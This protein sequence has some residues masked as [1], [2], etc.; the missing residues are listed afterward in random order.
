MKIVE[1][2]IHKARSLFEAI[3]IDKIGRPLKK[4]CEEVKQ[5]IENMHEVARKLGRA[6]WRKV[7]IERYAGLFKRNLPPLS[8]TKYM[9][10]LLVISL[11]RKLDEET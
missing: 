4:E 9:Y 7:P 3:N 5:A 2:V 1:E 6:I 8:R 10:F 11:N